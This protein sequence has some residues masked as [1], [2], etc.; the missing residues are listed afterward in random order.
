MCFADQRRIANVVERMRAG[1]DRFEDRQVWLRFA[2]LIIDQQGRLGA[3]L[4]AGV[5]HHLSHILGEGQVAEQEYRNPRFIPGKLTIV[6]EERIVF[7]WDSLGEVEYRRD[8]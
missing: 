5:E 7:R 2:H 3:K 1:T 6:N 4:A 8:D